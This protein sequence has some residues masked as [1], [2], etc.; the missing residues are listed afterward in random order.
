M[1]TRKT[2]RTRTRSY[3]TRV[4]GPGNAVRTMIYGRATG[5]KS[6]DRKYHNANRALEAYTRESVYNATR[7]NRQTIVR[8]V[9]RTS[10]Y[11][12]RFFIDAPRRCLKQTAAEPKTFVNPKPISHTCGGRPEEKGR[13][14]RIRGEKT[15][16]TLNIII[17]YHTIVR[18][19]QSTYR[20]RPDRP[21]DTRKILH[22]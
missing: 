6:D 20:N 14:R 17:I 12:N 2:A 21:G 9:N 13:A 19:N 18:I 11:I 1:P 16:S 8:V 22:D 7:S 5:R 10:G 15:Y 3:R 4:R